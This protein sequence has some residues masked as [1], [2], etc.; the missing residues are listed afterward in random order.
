MFLGLFLAKQKLQTP[1][2]HANKN[3]HRAT[4]NVRLMSLLAFT[5]TE[6]EVLYCTFVLLLRIVLYCSFCLVPYWTC[7]GPVQVSVFAVTASVA[8]AVVVSVAAGVAV[9]AWTKKWKIQESGIRI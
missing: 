3:A 4:L 9:A 1:A 8:V 2:E 5:E 6:F 7:A